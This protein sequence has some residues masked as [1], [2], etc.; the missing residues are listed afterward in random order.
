[1]NWTGL[2]LALP[3]VAFGIW[4]NATKPTCSEGFMPSFWMFG[5]RWV[6]VPG[7]IP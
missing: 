5:M 3:V 7:Y 1:M 2:A 4:M 6:C